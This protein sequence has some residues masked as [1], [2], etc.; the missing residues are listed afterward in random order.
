MNGCSNM[1]YNYFTEELLGLQEVKITNIENEENNIIIY[2]KMERK[3]HSCPCCGT[4]TFIIEPLFVSKIHQFQPF[5]KTSEPFINM[6]Y[7]SVTV[8]IVNSL[9]I[10]RGKPMISKRIYM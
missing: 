1:L 9:S 8:C 5:L 4:P 2:L 7:C 10:T 6:E 3:S